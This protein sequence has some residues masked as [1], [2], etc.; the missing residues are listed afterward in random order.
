MKTPNCGVNGDNIWTLEGVRQYTGR[1]GP[2]VE[3]DSHL[4]K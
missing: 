1:E 4:L 3:T 2:R